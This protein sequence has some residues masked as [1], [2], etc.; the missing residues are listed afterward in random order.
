MTSGPTPA[1]EVQSADTA[2]VT[3]AAVAK[4]AVGNTST[5]SVTVKLDKGSPVITGSRFP[6]PNAA[7]WN[8]GPVTVNFTCSD[9]V[10]GIRSCP[11]A[12]T[13][14]DSGAGRPSPA[15]PSTTPATRRPRR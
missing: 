2:G 14:S 3:R 12:T 7:G 9:T 8:Y 13:V 1:A 15:R 10:S 5:G 11:G 6:A 4:D